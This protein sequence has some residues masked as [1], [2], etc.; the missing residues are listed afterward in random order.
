M[1]QKLNVEEHNGTNIDGKFMND[2]PKITVYKIICKDWIA[3]FHTGRQLK[4]TV[5]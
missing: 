2:L 1:I 5:T 3:M 4:T